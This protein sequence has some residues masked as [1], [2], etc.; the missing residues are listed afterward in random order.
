MTCLWSTSQYGKLLF[1]PQRIEFKDI[2]SQTISNLKSQAEK[3][4]IEISIYNPENIVLWADENM[5][6]TVLRILVSNAIKFSG[7]RSKIVL[8]AEKNSLN[9]LITV[10]DNGVGIDKDAQE[11]LFDVSRGI[12]NEGTMGEKGTGLGLILCKEFIE[13]H[14]GHI[15]VE[16]EIG[17]GSDF[18]FTLLHEH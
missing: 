15:W 18:K 3:K 6:R 2:C 8:S 1:K 16:S 14:K 5:L 13:K 17:I 10:S 7:Y 9:T 12:S 11:K 4:Q